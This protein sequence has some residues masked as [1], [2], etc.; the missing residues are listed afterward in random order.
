[1]KYNFIVSPDQKFWI[2]GAKKLFIAEP[3]V[4]HAM[5]VNGELQNYEDIKIA[6]DYQQTREALIDDHNF[7]DQKYHK[8]VPLLANKLNEIHN[9]KYDVLFWQKSFSLSLIRY[10]KYFYDIFQV[11][12]EYFNPEFH[13]CQ[14]L[15][16]ESYYTPTDFDDQRNFFQATA[17]GQEQIFSI[18][19]NLFHPQR[20]K[21]IEDQFSW[22]TI[23]ESKR[24]SQLKRKLSNITMDKLILRIIA[25]IY[26]IREPK[27]GIVNSFFSAKNL[28]EI[29]GKSNGLIRPIPLKADF[30]FS[31][32]LDWEKRE[33]ITASQDDFDRFDDFFFSSLKYCFPKIFI[34]GF[35]EVSN[36]YHQFFKSFKKLK[37]VVN[38]A[39]IGSNYS[40][41]AMA[42][43]QKQG[44]KHI[45]N[46]H[47]FLSHHFLCNNHKYLLP[48]VDKFVTLGWFK[49]NTPKLVKGAS[50]FE[51][52]LD[53]EYKMEHDLL[54]ITGQPAVKAPEISASYGDFGSCNAKSHLKFNH[55]F[56]SKLKIPTV[57]S[58]VF[59]GYPVDGFVV[60]HLQPPMVAYD[61]DYVLSEYLKDCKL[62]DNVSL[63]A[64]KLMQ[65]S[66]L[67]IID[68]LST[69]YV[70]SM[71]ADIPT[72]FFWNQENYPL[73]EE[74]L[75]FYSSLIA[76]GICQTDPSEAAAFI[77][78]IKDNPEEWWQQ[79]SVQNAKK[80]FL[81]TNFGSVHI[82]TEYLLNLSHSS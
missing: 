72:I 49:T 2:K 36:Y 82:L 53:K 45:Y 78:K 23:P 68:Y 21:S 69:S 13:D 55:I 79:P 16:I 19:I 73:E 12:E 64:K 9:T 34:E 54:F 25:Q 75:D 1:M 27:V 17:F 5:E 4:H 71:L 42:I 11:C 51:W 48:L 18:Y 38:E 7:V 70:E 59:R 60:S 20:F 40:S 39:W 61:Q 43:L 26:K 31:S 6:S 28:K 35:N 80:L 50:L 57:Q 74:Y 58:M 14:V 76:V 44:I 46:E 29:I 52:Y 41:L 30:N 24:I 65:K 56:F 15:S 63:S 10:I 37:Y 8:Y 67:V 47:N 81:S 77:E 32:K 33:S 22:P 66:K 62:I 3:Y